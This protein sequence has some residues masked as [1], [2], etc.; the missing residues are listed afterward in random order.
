MVTCVDLLIFLGKIMVTCL[1]TCGNVSFFS[2]ISVFQF[3]FHSFVDSF[4][5]CIAFQW[6][7]LYDRYTKKINKII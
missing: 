1:V 4:V 3:I 5:I 2:S 6:P 7:K